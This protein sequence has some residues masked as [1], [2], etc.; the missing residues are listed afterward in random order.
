M[1]ALIDAD[2]PLFESASIGTDK[3]TG[4]HHS[5]DYVEAVFLNKIQEILTAVEA[6]TYTL[7]LTGKG[8]FRYDVATVKPYKGTRVNE[9]PFHYANLKAYIMSLP[10]GV[11]VEGMEADDALA[12]AQTKA[13]IARRND[14]GEVD[15]RGEVTCICTRDKDLRQVEGWHYGWEMGSQPEFPLQH[16][17]ELGGLELTRKLKEDGRVKS[18]KLTGTGAKF[19]YS[20]LITGDTVDNIP[21]LPG[22]GA[23]VAYDSLRYCESELEMY[24]MVSLLYHEKYGD[25]GEERLLEQAYLLWMIRELNEDGSP[26]MWVPPTED[27]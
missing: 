14:E 27:V 22:K 1:R 26:V 12:I 17:S 23:V 13:E 2:I 21:G 19:F 24:D 3:E 8:N 11:L 5:F 18:T 10:Q 7:F 15:E 20:Q 9:K 4:V 6:E 16:V 25:E